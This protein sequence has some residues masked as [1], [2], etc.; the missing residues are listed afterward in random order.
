MKGR[1]AKKVMRVST[2]VIEEMELEGEEVEIDFEGE[3]REGDVVV[4]P[5][6]ILDVVVQT[7]QE[8]RQGNQ[9]RPVESISVTF[10]ESLVSDGMDVDL[11]EE[12]EE[13]LEEIAKELREPE[14]DVEGSPSREIKEELIE[15]KM[16]RKDR[17]TGDGRVSSEKTDEIER[18]VIDDSAEVESF[19][20]RA[21]GLR[22]DEPEPPREI[23]TPTLKSTPY[24]GHEREIRRPRQC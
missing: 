11:G 9:I 12:E 14:R 15:Q 6:D 2:P 23:L 8:E 22:G 16:T 17:K 4:I 19:M 18:I 13:I 24:E 10:L 5:Q 20:V 3:R 7:I 21:A 1:V